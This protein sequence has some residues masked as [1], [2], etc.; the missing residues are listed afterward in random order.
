MNLEYGS[1]NNQSDV[2]EFSNNLS[3]LSPSWDGKKTTIKRRTK[4][5]IMSRK[6]NEMIADKF[7]EIC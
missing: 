5:E 1:N 2:Q 7:K 6:H 3:Y 4:R